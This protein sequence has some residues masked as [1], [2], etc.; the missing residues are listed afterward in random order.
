[1]KIL[2]A[3]FSNMVGDSGGTAKVN[4]AFANEMHRLGHTVSIMYSDDHEGAFFFPLDE[5]IAAYN[6]RH[7]RGQDVLLPSRLKLK[8]EI[9]RFF[10]MQRSRTVAVDFTARYLE[11]QIRTLLEELAPDVIVCFQ[12][13]AS[14]VFVC[15]LQTNIPVVNMSHG[16]TADYFRTEPAA[17]LPALSRCAA[18]QVLT[19]A[20]ER[21]IRQHVP[22][23][24]TVVIGNVVPQYPVQAD[25]RR[26]K[27][28]R[29]VLFIGR[30]VKNHKRPHLLIEAFARLAARFP[31][32][33]AE[34]WGAENR[35]SYQ[36]SLQKQ[37]AR[38][39]L[40]NRVFL[41][42]V[43]DDVAGVLQQG[44]LFIFPS[45][46]EGFGLT[47]AEAMSM[48]LPAIGYRS[49]S[50]VNELIRDG[51]NG[52]LC[53]DGV[54]PLAEQMARLMGDAELRARMGEAARL[55]MKPYAPEVIWPAWESL[56]ER[57]VRGE[58]I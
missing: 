25:L 48:G 2:L 44:D 22:Q 43:T 55:S 9:W 6:L 56:L 42:G 1:M 28:R 24:H 18:C 8:R 54:E 29:R 53:A 34:L 11:K 37:I 30:L 7:F 57:A 21:I 33:E 50:A 39:G 49:C 45:M 32:W 52:F 40:E 47:L 26:P 23:A 20:F 38:H 31:D 14:K 12:L 46:S 10:S 3:N 19:P 15:D 4:C 58:K 13:A 35:H 5:G 17:N 51:E 16:D 41:R 27:P 36:V